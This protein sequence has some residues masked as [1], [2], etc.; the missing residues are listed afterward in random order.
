M[1]T[2]LFPRGTLFSASKVRTPR[3]GYLSWTLQ[4]KNPTKL[5]T[6]DMCCL[7]QEQTCSLPAVALSSTNMNLSHT[8]TVLSHHFYICKCKMRFYKSANKVFLFY[9]PYTQTSGSVKVRQLQK[10]FK[11]S[12][13]EMCQWL[14]QIQPHHHVVSVLRLHF[15][16]RFLWKHNKKAKFKYFPSAFTLQTL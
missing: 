2:I 5:T 13:N 15:P 6:G 7:P 16:E 11:K 12:I 4:R 14:Q 9:F 1:Y 8:C 3:S 10:V